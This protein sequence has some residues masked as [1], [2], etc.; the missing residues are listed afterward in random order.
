MEIT[1]KRRTG[2]LGALTPIPLEF[3]GDMITSLSGFQEKVVSIPVSEGTL[4]YVE[5]LNRS[6]QVRVRQ[7]DVI[8]IRRT[9]LSKVT[10]LLFVIT[11]LYF[12]SANI[13][14]LVTGAPYDHEWAGLLRLLLAIA[15][16]V[17]GIT[18]LFFN[19]YKLVVEKRL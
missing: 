4:K 8:T 17:V 1:V 9:T 14:I 2:I 13:Y 16:I 11:L 18:S 12:L 19:T 10:H 6:D 3:N 15:F 5:S 7:G